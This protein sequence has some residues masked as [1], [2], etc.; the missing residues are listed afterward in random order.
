[1]IGL[2]PPLLQRQLGN[3]V[4]PVV[5]QHVAEKPFRG[6]RMV[7]GVEIGSYRLAPLDACLGG[8]VRAL[9]AP[10]DH[11]LS[12][13]GRLDDAVPDGVASECAAPVAI[14]HFIPLV[15]VFLRPVALVH[16]AVV[17][18]E[19]NLAAGVAP[20]VRLLPIPVDRAGFYCHIRRSVEHQPVIVVAENAVR[21][22]QPVR[23]GFVVEPGDPIGLQQAALDCHRAVVPVEP[24]PRG[25]V[26]DGLEAE[27][28]DVAAFPE[29]LESRRVVPVDLLAISPVVVRALAILK[30]DSFGQNQAQAAFAVVV[31]DA[32]PEGRVLEH[33][34]E[35]DAVVPVEA[36]VLEKDVGALAGNGRL[37]DPAHR[38]SDYQA[39]QNRIRVLVE[40]QNRPV[41]ALS[42]GVGPAH[43]DL[44]SGLFHVEC[45]RR[46]DVNL[47]V[48]LGDAE[49]LLDQLV[50]RENLPVRLSVYERQFPPP[51]KGSPVDVEVV[52]SHRPEGFGPLVLVDAAG[53]FPVREQV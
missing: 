47:L 24:D 2:L 25:V 46:L 50:L 5:L 10:V 34:V 35:T 48:G 31:G 40:V 15:E 16:D 18:D 52:I 17:G 20:L 11:G 43:G 23:V 8:D 29:R 27:E 30:Q 39:A 21:K 12:R 45:G 33:H 51:L 41:A 1:M 38:M 6:F 7:V 44:H 36:A 13:I 53:V 42:V 28:A 3:V 32:V 4:L 9:G 49:A 14:L 19:C 37:L 22:D 26:A